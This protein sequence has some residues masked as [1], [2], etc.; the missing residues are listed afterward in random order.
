M[1]SVT[2]KPN[3]LAGTI[4]NCE[5]CSH[6]LGN[7]FHISVFSSVFILDDEVRKDSQQLS[8]AIKVGCNQLSS[9]KSLRVETLL[10]LQVGFTLGR[11]FTQITTYFY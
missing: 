9:G 11:R 2:Y 4:K 6:K 8:F 5:N 3:C 1:I 7:R 10:V